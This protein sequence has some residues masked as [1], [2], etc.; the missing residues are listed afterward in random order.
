LEDASDGS[1]DRS[2]IKITVMGGKMDTRIAE[3][4]ES[5][6]LHRFLADFRRALLVYRKAAL[7]LSFRLR[8]PIAQG[9]LYEG[10][11]SEESLDFLR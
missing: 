9:P 1:K 6:A 3:G 7:N 10:V 5:E 2:I 8:F 11:C 4:L